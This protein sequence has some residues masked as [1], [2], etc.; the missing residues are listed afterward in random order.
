MD[1]IRILSIDGGGI[2]GIIPLMVLSEIEKKTQLPIHELFQVIGGTSTGAI[3]CLGLNSI[4]KTTQKIYTANEL[5]KL[6]REKAQDIFKRRNN[7]SDTARDFLNWTGLSSNKGAGLGESQYGKEGIEEFLRNVFGESK[8]MSEL[9]TLCDIT[10]CSYD[11]EK[12]RTYY[13]RKQEKGQNQSEDYLVWQ[14]ARATSAAPTFF[15]ASEIKD[16]EREQQSTFIDGGVFINNPSLKLYCTAKKIYPEKQFMLVS[17]GTGETHNSYPQRE[18]GAYGW[19]KKGELLEI[20]MKGVAE[21]VDEVMKELLPESEGHKT[22]YRMQAQLTEPIELD[23]IEKATLDKLEN[24]G[25]KVVEDNTDHLNWLCQKLQERIAF[26]WL[27][28]RYIDQRKMD[29]V[30]DSGRSGASRKL[31]VYRP[32]EDLLNQGWYWLGHYGTNDESKERR[33][34]IVR[35]L[36]GGDDVFTKPKSY[37][38]VWSDE[39]VKTNWNDYSAWQIIAPPGYKALGALMRLKTDNYHPPSENEVRNLMCVREDLCVGAKAGDASIWDDEG[40]WADG[41]CTL[42]PIQPK[43]DGINAGTFLCYPHKKTEKPA[44]IEECVIKKQIAQISTLS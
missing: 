29:K 13:F 4:N 38:K 14:A 32:S 22:Y 44:P 37:Q 2:R 17:L 41:D 18:E 23:H 1:T 36:R 35:K 19:L 34:I 6:Y 3:I 8:R 5:L 16:A 26:P 39:G 31:S 15:P 33:T 24:Y 10:V 20:M 43:Q 21:S 9:P 42:W 40:T 27:E 28:V 30:G 11:I 25:K 12:D 7:F